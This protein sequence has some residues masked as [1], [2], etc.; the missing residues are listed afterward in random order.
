ML[1]YGRMSTNPNWLS[2]TLYFDG[3]SYFSAVL[4][5]IDKAQTSIELETYIYYDDEFGREVEHHLEAALD[6]GV[7]VRLLVDGIGSVSWLS[8]KP[9][10]TKVPL[11]IW[12]PLVYGPVIWSLLRSLRTGRFLRPLL[13]V[14]RRTHRKYCIIDRRIGFVGSLN[15]S[16]DHLSRF[17]GKL[18]W[19]D[20]GVRIEGEGL[21]ILNHAF[22]Y[23]WDRAR[24]PAGERHWMGRHAIGPI[25]SNSLVRIN[26]NRIT[27]RRCRQDLISRLRKA[28]HRIW[29]T[30]AYF[31]PT[32]PLVKALLE[33][34]R[35][36]CDVRILVPATSDVFFMHWVAT[37]FYG[38]LLE[39][40][41]RI[42]EYQPTFLHAKSMLI[43]DWAI[44]GTSNINSRSV[45]HDLE[46]DIVLTSAESRHELGQQYERDLSR[47]RE[48]ST[49]EWRG[50]R[51]A[52]RAGNLFTYFLRSWL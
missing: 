23:A 16:R 36:G 22:D 4:S 45:L 2:E 31:V 26:V 10:H 8:R 43:D 7:A 32:A 9:A 18:A 20:T 30:S 38:V 11:R 24:T 46:I 19:R 5:A 34:R 42:F 48:I 13:H 27:R 40:G 14:N 49:V 52:R 41:V 21:E 17:Y 29:I 25:R 37:S 12:N 50:W 39:G 6:R 28:R 47:S 35:A 1:H 3:D 33:S 44:V 51:W 15:I